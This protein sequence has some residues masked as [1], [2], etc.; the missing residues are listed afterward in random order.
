MRIVVFKSIRVLARGELRNPGFY[1][2]PAYESGSFVQL[3]QPNNSEL[4]LFIGTNNEQSEI[5]Q[6]LKSNNKSLNK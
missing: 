2:F 3:D 5:D 1:K 4:D 6:N